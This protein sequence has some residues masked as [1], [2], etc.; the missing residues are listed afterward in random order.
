[1]KFNKNNFIISESNPLAHAHRRWQRIIIS[2]ALFLQAL[3]APKLS[4]LGI[5]VLFDT[6]EDSQT[7][8]LQLLVMLI[9][10]IASTG[11]LYFIV[12]KTGMYL[13]ERFIVFKLP[14]NRQ[15]SVGGYWDAE[16]TF[17]QN[18]SAKNNQTEIGCAIIKQDYLGQIEVSLHY[19][20][21]KDSNQ[22]RSESNMSGYMTTEG[23]KSK[24]HIHFDTTHKGGVE[25]SGVPDNAYGTET[26][27]V[28]DLTD[29]G[30]PVS[31]IGNFFFNKRTEVKPLWNGNTKYTRTN[32]MSIKNHV[33]DGY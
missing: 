20:F 8:M 29:D 6:P 26:V 22:Y 1:M 24:F 27:K 31:L 17:K 7:K 18:S 28:R 10:H 25:Y 3:S 30:Y 33:P 23:G 19:G 14:K 5:E 16:F 9:A 15:Y 11:F 12:Y 4:D 21:D 2:V 32:E 13:Y